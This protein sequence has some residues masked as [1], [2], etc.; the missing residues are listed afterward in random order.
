MLRT[1]KSD[2]DTADESNPYVAFSGDTKI[3]LLFHLWVN[4]PPIEY[5]L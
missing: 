2:D 4:I 3:K 1:R 5:F